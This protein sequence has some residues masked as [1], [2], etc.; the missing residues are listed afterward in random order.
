[1]KT[2]HTADEIVTIEGPQD[3]SLDF[4]RVYTVI[5]DEMRR[6]ETAYVTFYFI[7]N[8][9]HRTHS[10]D[11]KAS[12]KWGS[13]MATLFDEPGVDSV[14]KV[15]IQPSDQLG[16]AKGNPPRLPYLIVDRSKKHPMYLRFFGDDSWDLVPDHYQWSVRF[17]RKN[18]AEQ[19]LKTVRAD[20]PKAQIEP[21]ENYANWKKTRPLTAEEFPEPIQNPREHRSTSRQGH[22]VAN[23]LRNPVLESGATFDA[24][25]A[26]QVAKEARALS[27]L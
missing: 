16:K 6:V 27:R 21:D 7:Y 4:D 23:L 8:G 18:Q 9:K 13:I 26:E 24:S 17:S 14:Y 1:M 2:N 20:Y 3:H 25:D 22:F 11:F 12:D 10:D 19:W 15:T 5:K